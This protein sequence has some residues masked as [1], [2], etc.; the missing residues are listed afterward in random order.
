[1][2][3]TSNTATKSLTITSVFLYWWKSGRRRAPIARQSELTWSWTL[4]QIASARAL[5]NLFGG[6]FIWSDVGFFFFRF[7]PFWTPLRT[8]RSCYPNLK[9]L[10]HSQFL[11]KIGTATW[12]RHSMIKV[13]L[14]QTNNKC[15]NVSGTLNFWRELWRL[16]MRFISM[17]KVSLWQT[18]SDVSTNS[19]NV[20]LWRQTIVYGEQ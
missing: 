11:T 4:R 3:L 7:Y 16:L 6:D 15:W 17:I 12:M 13:P 5:F 19:T 1:M 20:S 10:G 9:G 14:W 8:N 18:T 2:I